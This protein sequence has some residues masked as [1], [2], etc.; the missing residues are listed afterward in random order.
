METLLLLLRD[1]PALTQGFIG[2]ILGAVLV[3][4]I[5]WRWT[6]RKRKHAD[7]GNGG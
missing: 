1:N 7:N 5:V 6:I 3:N 2:G 4:A